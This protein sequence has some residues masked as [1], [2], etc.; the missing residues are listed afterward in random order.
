LRFTAY[1]FHTWTRWCWNRGKQVVT[2][3]P[4]TGWSISD[5][6]SQYYWQGIASKD[7]YFY[8][9]GKNNGYPKSAYMHNRVGQFDNCVLKYG[10]IGTSYA[11]NKIRSYYN[12]TWSWV[13]K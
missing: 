7:L 6:D 13:T 8:D 12:G 2:G 4:T 9:Y 10:C 5:I 11:D 1:K 3:N